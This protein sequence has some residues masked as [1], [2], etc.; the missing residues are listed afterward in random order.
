MIEGL[1][2]AA[3]VEEALGWPGGGSGA[4]TR[5]AGGVGDGRRAR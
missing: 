2:V 3:G 5:G 1:G 4:A